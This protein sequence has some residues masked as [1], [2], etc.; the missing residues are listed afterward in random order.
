[1][2]NYKAV[3]LLGGP[4]TVQ[5]LRDIFTNRKDRITCLV[6]TVAAHGRATL[7]VGSAE[8]NFEC[9]QDISDL[10]SQLAEVIRA[11]PVCVHQ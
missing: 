6:R 11:E 2:K 9:L 1:M 7:S 3:M 8:F 10:V 4:E 5:E